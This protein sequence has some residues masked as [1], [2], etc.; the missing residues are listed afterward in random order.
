M[1]E[2]TSE[3][4][5]FGGNLPSKAH[6][7]RKQSKYR[8]GNRLIPSQDVLRKVMAVLCLRCGKR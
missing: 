7:K 5:L 8:S 3:L 4:Q 1:E 2:K 6:A